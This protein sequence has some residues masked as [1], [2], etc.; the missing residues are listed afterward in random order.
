[1]EKPGEV[2]KIVR[3]T[4]SSGKLDYAPPVVLNETSKSRLQ[5]IAWF[6]RHNDGSTELSLKLE[7]FKKD[8]DQPWIEDKTKTLTLSHAASLQLLKYLQS[9]LPVA[10]QSE[11]GEFILIRV[12]NGEAVLT[13]HDPQALVSALTNVLSQAELLG[14]CACRQY[15][16]RFRRG[17][18][19]R[20]KTSWGATPS[21]PC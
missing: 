16:H 17:A 19:L 13:G 2:Q 8:K 14:Q 5:A 4:A 18:D 15:R 1:M 12:A 10:E 3:K 21:C 6:I 20:H 11:A 7:G 9:H